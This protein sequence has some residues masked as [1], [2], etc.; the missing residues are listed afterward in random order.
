MTP[1][2]DSPPSIIDVTVHDDVVTFA[3][4]VVAPAAEAPRVSVKPAIG[5]KGVVDVTGVLDRGRDG[6][7]RVVA[8][9]CEAERA[10]APWNTAVVVDRPGR[11]LLQLAGPTVPGR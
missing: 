9:C 11:S 4:L 5:H 10:S 7:A 3:V 1:A 6:D 8:F 2:P